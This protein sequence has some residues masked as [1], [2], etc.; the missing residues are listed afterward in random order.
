MTDGEPIIQTA[1]AV[2]IVVDETAKKRP[3]EKKKKH[4][5]DEKR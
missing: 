3:K 5:H 2:K 4:K 1:G